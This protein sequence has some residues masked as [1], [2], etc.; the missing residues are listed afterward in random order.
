MNQIMLL[1][2]IIDEQLH[3][4]SPVTSGWLMGELGIPRG[5]FY[6]MI[7]G[8]L[9]SKLIFRVKRGQYAVNGSWL[10]SSLLDIHRQYDTA[11]WIKIL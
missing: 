9:D 4:D 5:T 11:K 10:V 3:N 6:R 7:N 8:L 1:T 2:V